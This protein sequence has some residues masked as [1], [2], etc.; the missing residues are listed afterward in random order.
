[1]SLDFEKGPDLALLL[2]DDRYRPHRHALL[3]LVIL[4]ISFSMFFDA[5][6]QLNTSLN[7]FYG[8][9]SY[10][11]FINLL[12]YFNAFVLFPRFLA[13]SRLLAYIV[14]VLLF[15]VFALLLMMVL[16]DLF[17]DIAVSHQQP[18]PVAMV[19]NVA[20]SMLAVLLFLGGVSTLLLFK[21]WMKANRRVQA[22]R[23]ATLRSELGFLQSQINPHFLFNMMNNAAI[24]VREDP[25]TA[26]QILV[27]LEAMLAYQFKEGTKDTVSLQKDIAFLSDFLALEKVRRDHF[28]YSVV[29]EGE[30]GSRQVPALLFIPF[31]ENAVK[32]NLDSNRS[33]VHVRFRMEGDRLLFHCVNSK[34]LNP[35][36]R[37][38]GGLGLKNSRRRLDLLFE[39]DYVLEI[40]ETKS[41]YTVRLQLNLSKARI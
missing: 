21:Q 19:L 30:M 32:H 18:T 14:A 2:T 3:Q 41:T 35:V 8:W 40:E 22:L 4:T 25:E 7:R 13:R 17:Y 27:K 9:I 10:V 24:L 34:P 39:K 26:E 1:M 23:F 37:M 6:D 15:T 36:Y 38:V 33:Y 20:S 31:V 29:Q 12:V 16:Q 11:L 5:P 28:E